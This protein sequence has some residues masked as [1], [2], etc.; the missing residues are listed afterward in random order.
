MKKRAVIVVEAVVRSTSNSSDKSSMLG[1]F[2]W[3]LL[4]RSLVQQRAFL[5]AGSSWH[6]HL[7]VA[8]ACY[9]R[10]LPTSTST[11]QACASGSDHGLCSVQKLHAGDRENVHAAKYTVLVRLLPCINTEPKLSPCFHL[12]NNG[13]LRRRAHWH[14]GPS[15]R[16]HTSSRRQKGRNCTHCFSHCTLSPRMEELFSA[17]LC[18]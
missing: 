12:I 8:G 6:G 18:L 1:L 13:T 2:A 14:P 4:Y 10:Y 5:Q 15:L 3:L 11:S 16:F 17:N 7:L 9:Q